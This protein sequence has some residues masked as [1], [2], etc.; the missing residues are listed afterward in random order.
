MKKLSIIYESVLSEATTPISPDEIGKALEKH[1]KE[2]YNS[3]SKAWLKPIFGGK[4]WLAAEN[5]VRIDKNSIQVMLDGSSN[6][7][8]KKDVGVSYLL[9]EMDNLN[10]QAEKGFLGGSKSYQVNYDILISGTDD[11]SYNHWENIVTEK[12]SFKNKSSVDIGKTL[13][14]GD[15]I[16][17]MFDEVGK[18]SID[19]FEQKVPEYIKA[20]NR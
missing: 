17:Q 11:P 16:K 5:S 8:M 20:K 15:L 12:L 10:I 7:H 1:K 6:A 9:I 3:I 14:D 4:K 13:I 18:I 2:F 19:K